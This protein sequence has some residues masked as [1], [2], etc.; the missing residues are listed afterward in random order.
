MKAFDL[1]TIKADNTT[2]PAVPMGT[3]IILIDEEMID[4]GKLEFQKEYNSL[5]IAH[6]KNEG[7]LKPRAKEMVLR[8]VPKLLNSKSSIVIV[9]PESIAQDMIF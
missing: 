9:C 5:T 7:E 1:I 4:V 3:P 2:E 8:K 6:P